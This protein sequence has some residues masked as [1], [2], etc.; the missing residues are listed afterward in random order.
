MYPIFLWSNIQHSCK[1][2][3]NTS[4][5]KSSPTARNLFSSL[6]ETPLFTHFIPTPD[7]TFQIMEFYSSSARFSI[8]RLYF[9]SIPTLP[10]YCWN[11]FNKFFIWSMLP[12]YSSWVH[13]LD[14]GLS[15][16]R[17]RSSWAP[18]PFGLIGSLERFPWTH[19]RICMLTYSKA[20][21]GFF[22]TCYLHKIF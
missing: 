2:W 4:L 21:I 17:Y 9:T 16:H 5:T 13:M 3:L 12:Q 22:L 1:S 15:I 6:P 8:R 18:I 19:T 14:I 10:D 20:S 11:H 7:L